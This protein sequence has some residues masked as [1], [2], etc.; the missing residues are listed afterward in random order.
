MMKKLFLLMSVCSMLFLLSC[1]GEVQTTQNQSPASSET[2]A[3]EPTDS[4]STE[5]Y[6]RTSRRL[7]RRLLPWIWDREH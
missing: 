4:A 5:D 7:S 3:T 6:D 1:G 2:P